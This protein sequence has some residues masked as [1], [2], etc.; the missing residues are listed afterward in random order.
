MKKNLSSIRL[1][2]KRPWLLYGFS[3][4]NIP[5]D[6]YVGDADLYM[7]GLSQPLHFKDITSVFPEK[8]IFDLTL[9]MAMVDQGTT[10][11]ILPIDDGDDGGNGPHIIENIYEKHPAVRSI[12]WSKPFNIHCVHH[13]AIRPNDPSWTILMPYDT[14][15]FGGL[16]EGEMNVRENQY[17]S[18]GGMQNMD[19]SMDKITAV[20]ARFSYDSGN[21]D[22]TEEGTFGLAVLGGGITMQMNNAQTSILTFQSYKTYAQQAQH[23]N[24]WNNDGEQYAQKYRSMHY[25]MLDQTTMR[26]YFSQNNTS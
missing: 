3:A 15:Q 9:S 18:Y 5:Q 26:V 4:P 19:T 24:D 22:M 21:I 20:N 2:Q 17:Y 10:V 11:V 6:N 23:H 25:Q 1:H 13:G 7:G 12:S 14:Y 8:V 16:E